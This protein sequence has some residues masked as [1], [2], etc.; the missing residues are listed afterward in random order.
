MIKKDTQGFGWFACISY[1]SGVVEGYNDYLD[2][3][4]SQIQVQPNLIACF[5]AVGH[6]VQQ[7]STSG[8][9]P[10]CGQGGNLTKLT[11][12]FKNSH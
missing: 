11:L 8:S 3:I 2:G 6:N 12:Q 10:A 9:D 5:Q 4:D 1:V 7:H